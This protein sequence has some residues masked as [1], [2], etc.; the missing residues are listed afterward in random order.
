MA[1]SLVLFVFGHGVQSSNLGDASA[2]ELCQASG[3]LSL[4]Q[5]RIDVSAPCN[6]AKYARSSRKVQENKVI[7]C[8]VG[9]S[10]NVQTEKVTLLRS[11]SSEIDEYRPLRTCHGLPA[12][13]RNKTLEC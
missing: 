2:R 5:V 1:S 10:C 13:R 3:D 8:D 7:L 9:S 12:D 4:E 11:S 6:P